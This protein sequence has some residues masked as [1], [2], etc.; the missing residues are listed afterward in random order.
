MIPII[1]ATIS[2]G[3]I[4]YY[5]VI[6]SIFQS[7]VKKKNVIEQISVKNLLLKTRILG[8]IAGIG[9]ATIVWPSPFPS[10]IGEF[11]PTFILWMLV[12]TFVGIWLLTRSFQEILDRL[13]EKYEKNY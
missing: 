4:I 1:G 11:L 2:I 5:L 7:R 3:A 12:C 10:T 6:S 8:T 13:E 9:S